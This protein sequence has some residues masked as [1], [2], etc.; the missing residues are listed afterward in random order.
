M[1]LLTISQACKLLNIGR[2]D[3]IRMARLQLINALKVKRRILRFYEDELMQI[4][5]GRKS[6]LLMRSAEYIR[7]KYKIGQKRLDEWAEQGE[8]NRHYDSEKGEHTYNE[9]EIKSMTKDLFPDRDDDGWFNVT[10]FKWEDK[11]P[12]KQFKEEMEKK[13]DIATI[14]KVAWQMKVE[15]VTEVEIDEVDESEKI[16]TVVYL[17]PKQK[18]RLERHAK[19]QRLSIS[20]ITSNAVERLLKK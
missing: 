19:L 15:E 1:K 11:S 8:I 5:N 20:E 4:V 6:Y 16:A 12:A 2:T 18:E 10:T 9:S 7:K 13:K 17:T 3:I 14:L